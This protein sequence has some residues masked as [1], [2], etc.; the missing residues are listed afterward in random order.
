LIDK[1]EFLL[2][3]SRT[4][5]FGKAAEACGVTQ[6]TLS[7]GVQALEVRLGV[8]LVNR[9]S[10]FIG[11][12]DEG[13]RVLGWARKIVAAER[14]ML[15]DLRTLRHGLSGNVRIGVIPTALAMAPA[16]TTPF[17][18]RHPGVH[19]TISALSSFDILHMLENLEL[20]AGLT[21]LESEPLGR[22]RAIPLFRE[23]YR[24][25]TAA[26]LP[27]GER[28][29]VSWREL[30]GLDLCLLTRDMQ[31]RR[32][33]DRL[34]ARDG[35]GHPPVLESNSIVTLLAHVRTGQWAS[36]LPETLAELAGAAGPVRSIPIVAPEIT[37]TIGL[38]VPSHDPATPLC[39]AL[40]EE[41][42]RR[43]LDGDQ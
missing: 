10:R 25:L 27:L 22:V 24:L 29:S 4:Q 30:A 42:S 33:L 32:I 15:D 35:A 3:L 26:H 19:F 41:A 12:T 37:Q 17:L 21:Y 36:I 1:L 38:V 23:R 40:V 34:L 7:A 2:A 18:A 5:H 28:D 6:P 9:G 31:N 43:R 13:A 14:G 20:E 16:L 8:R 11:F 39:N